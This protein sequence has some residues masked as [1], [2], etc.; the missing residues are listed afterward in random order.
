[1]PRS[2]NTP[3]AACESA[4]RNSSCAALR[5]PMANRSLAASSRL[6]ACSYL[7]VELGQGAEPPKSLRNRAHADRPF[8][9]TANRSAH[10]TKSSPWATRERRAACVREITWTPGGGRR[11]IDPSTTKMSRSLTG[12]TWLPRAQ[13]PTRRTARGSASPSGIRRSLRYLLPA[14]TPSEAIKRHLREAG[15]RLRLRTRLPE[16]SPAAPWPVLSPSCGAEHSRQRVPGAR[17]ECIPGPARVR[18]GPRAGGIRCRRRPVP[19]PR[20]EP[21]PPAGGARS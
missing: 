21:L 12:S 2:S 5:S 6:A 4:N 16:L 18:G 17:F 1:M 20:R 3:R 7:R 14:T 13:E 8:S 15:R 11:G 10:W 9:G 19:A